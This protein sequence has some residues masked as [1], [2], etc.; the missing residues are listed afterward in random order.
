[1][2]GETGAL[3]RFWGTD[4]FVTTAKAYS[5]CPLSSSPFGAVVQIDRQKRIEVRIGEIEDSTGH[6]RQVVFHSVAAWDD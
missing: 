5:G 3:R 2:S 1:M 4:S 6:K